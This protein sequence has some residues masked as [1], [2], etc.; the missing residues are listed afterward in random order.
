M[1]QQ[2]AEQTATPALGGWR[3]IHASGTRVRAWVA[4]PW[5]RRVVGLFLVTRL[6]LLLV[7]CIGFVLI[8]SPKYA[9]PSVGVGQLLGSWQQWD[10]VWY[11]R[12]AT[13]GYTTAQATAFFPLYPLLIA[14]LSAPFHGTAAYAAGLLISNGATLAALMLLY[15]LTAE[16]WGAD[17]A[18][19]A[20]TYLTVFPTA[21]FLFA[22]YNES[23]FIALTLGCFVALGQR[24]WA[25]AGVL[26]GL[27]ALTRSA[28]ILLLI[29][30]AWTVWQDVRL[31]TARA[32]SGSAPGGLHGAWQRVRPWLPALWAALM[33]LG[34]VI[35]AIYCGARFG[36]P[37]AFDHAQLVWNRVL[38]WPWQ[39]LVWQLQGLASAAPASFYQV[40]DL[41][42]LA[43]TVCFGALLVAGWNRLPRAQ[44]LYMAGLMVLILIEPGGVYLHTNDP[45]SSNS[46][47]VLEMFPGFILLGLWTS[48]RPALHQALVIGFSSL[49]AV[50]SIVFVLGRWLV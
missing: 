40:H 3:W 1:R 26:G 30:V 27:A 13:H 16:R 31:S 23:L 46:R 12:I 47:F 9:T 42:D 19:R 41:L 15:Q 25:L 11:I 44:T 2:T 45:L 18:W 35:F 32:G 17:V 21:L 36:D 24:R 5:V 20:V 22:P 39:G 50:L 37:L 43:A 33:P 4:T 29:P 48:Q 10:A 49:L 7:T 14:A 38:A 8:L 34:I 28:G 6:A